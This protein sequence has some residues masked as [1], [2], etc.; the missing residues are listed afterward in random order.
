MIF[1]HVHVDIRILKSSLHRY[2]NL[3]KNG[4]SLREINYSVLSKKI[5]IMILII[6]LNLFNILT[7]NNYL[8]ILLPLFVRS[9]CQHYYYYF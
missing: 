6:S 5:R 2:K 4:F 3:N 7:F 1:H 9:C 8:L